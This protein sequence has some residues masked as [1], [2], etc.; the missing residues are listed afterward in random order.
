MTDETNFDQQTREFFTR[1]KS[2]IEEQELLIGIGDWINRSQLMKFL[3]YGDT[4]MREL[5]NSGH[6]TISQV[7]RRKFISKKS[8]YKFLENHIIIVSKD[9]K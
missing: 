7:G 4:Q 1:L 6:L 8:L 3:K 5:E 9:G 2:R